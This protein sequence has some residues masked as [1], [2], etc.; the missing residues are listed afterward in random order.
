MLRDNWPNASHH[1]SRETVL[2]VLRGYGYCDVCNLE[3]LPVEQGFGGGVTR[4]RVRGVDIL[5]K[6]MDEGRSKQSILFSLR[7]QHLFRNQGI[8][9]PRFHRTLS[10]ELFSVLGRHVFTVQDWCSGAKFTVEKSGAESRRHYRTCVGELL[11]RM[12]AVADQSLL[13]DVPA[14]CRRTAHELFREIPAVESVLRWNRAGRFASNVWISIHES[15]EFARE[16]RHALDLLRAARSRLV[17]SG[18]VLDSRYSVLLP[19]HGDIQFENLLFENDRISAVIDFD[20]AMVRSQAYDLGS[21]MAV[22]CAQREHEEDFLRAYVEHAGD[23]I[24]DSQLL[25]ECV[26]LRNTKSLLNQISHYLGKKSAV[27]PEKLR[28]FMR[29]YICS[30]EIELASV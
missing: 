30:L 13:I 22:V 8:A 12:H 29:Q 27:S 21:T 4:V 17:R 24:V 26:L 1:F 2:E 16:L 5:L 9:C 3:I 6:R 14:A 28:S 20:N 10:G 11:G 7:V 25:R 23:S 18:A 15:G 19:V